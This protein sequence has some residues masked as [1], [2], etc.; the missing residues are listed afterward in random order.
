M[1]TR[2]IELNSFDSWSNELVLICQKRNTKLVDCP[3]KDMTQ[4]NKYGRT[5]SPLTGQQNVLYNQYDYLNDIY[6][7]H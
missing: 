4:T 6:H 1:N 7:L 3:T 2:T 5:Q